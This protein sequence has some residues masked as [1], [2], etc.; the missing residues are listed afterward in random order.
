MQWF[1]NM[2]AVCS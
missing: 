1:Q 2:I